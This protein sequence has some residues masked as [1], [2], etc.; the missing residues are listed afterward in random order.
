MVK[1]IILQPHA[2]PPSYSQGAE[3]EGP[4]LTFLGIPQSQITREVWKTRVEGTN[5][6]T[7]TGRDRA[8]SSIQGQQRTWEQLAT[9]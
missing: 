7:A 6:G 4:R 9:R 1:V 3:G 5:W 8:L 2:L